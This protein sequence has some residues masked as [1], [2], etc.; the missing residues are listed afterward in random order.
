MAAP[1]GAALVDPSLQPEHLLSRHRVVVVG[2]VAAIDEVAG[3]VAI[4]VVSTL[5]GTAPAPR[6]VLTVAAGQ[7]DAALSQETEHPGLLVEAVPG[8]TVVAM[9]GKVR[10]GVGPDLA[11]LYL[12]NHWHE[13]TIPAGGPAGRLEWT[14]SH[15]DRMWGTFNGRP[16][17]L[18]EL[19]RD[20][21]DGRGFF[22]ALPYTA[23]ADER[24]LARL[25]GLP[26]GVVVCDLD[27]DGRLDIYACA[28]GGDRQLRQRVDGGF[29]PLPSA[30]TSASV[31]VADA[32]GDGVIDLLLDGALRRGQGGGG[33][34][35]AQVLPG[36]D[37]ADVLVAAFVELDG[38]GWPDV[39][40]V[41]RAGGIRALINPGPGV[42]VW[43][44]VSATWGLE[45]R[46]LAGAA[47][48][49]APGDLD[50]DGR[51]DLVLA[52]GR[53]HVLLQRAA[54]RFT[55]AAEI[56][57]LDFGGA[58]GRAGAG[59][60]AALWSGASTEVVLPG[61]TGLG[62][63]AWQ[64][65][66]R[67]LAGF[68]NELVQSGSRQ[69]ATL[70]EDLNADGR[71]DLL[72][73][74][75]TTASTGTLYTNRGYG[76]FMIEAL[77]AKDAPPMPGLGYGASGLA[78]G[79]IDGDGAIDVVMVGVDGALRLCRN[80]SLEQRAE[81]PET[82]QRSAL[83]AM[84]Q[85]RVR[86]SSRRGVLGAEVRL[87][88]AD[89]GVLTRRTVGSQVLTGCRGPDEILFTVPAAGRWRVVVRFADGLE[90][91]AEATVGDAL[92]TVVVPR[93]E[94]R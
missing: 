69:A 65:G 92:A 22:P 43:R 19:L 37:P 5:R 60:I 38:D 57:G 15:G 32:D 42:G 9:I 21:V 1:P 54:G 87:L 82:A 36:L 62:L 66:L 8:D 83:M 77:Y 13:A 53:G 11:L 90:T 59:C 28:R 17:R 46:E 31:G 40:A 71:L 50:G 56:G 55:L 39:V 86:P 89:G 27:G 75:R 14:T 44:D 64:G 34:A 58:D 26:G 81:L 29:D 70:A 73:L 67:S 20:A 63:F 80:R 4:D 72:S 30:A 2:R 85:L 51:T 52:A 61:D 24:V 6:L 68:G 18:A 7:R 33:F 49:F 35:P 78:A 23:F 84:R 94:G 74:G 10:A 25:S 41:R 48:W 16:D 3:T 47:G 91:V 88:A 93:P 76:T 45:C 79:D 12:G